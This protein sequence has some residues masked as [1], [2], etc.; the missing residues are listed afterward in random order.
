MKRIDMSRELSALMD[1]FAV[2][3]GAPL[4]FCVFDGSATE[5]RAGWGL[6]SFAWDGLASFFVGFAGGSM[7]PGPAATNNNAEC[8]GLLV[9]LT[10]AV[11]VPATVR[12]RIFVDSTLCLWKTASTR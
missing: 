12:T 2:F 3:G 9:A 11:S 6:A 4:E 5:Q 1:D 7:S 8:M 10:R